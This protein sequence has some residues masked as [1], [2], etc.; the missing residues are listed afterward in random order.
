MHQFLNWCRRGYII[1]CKFY[2]PV[3]QQYSLDQKNWLAFTP[4]LDW[5]LTPNLT[6]IKVPAGAPK[7][8][9]GNKVVGILNNPEK[10]RYR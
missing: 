8:S 10:R 2:A 7:N 5:Y 6:G 3:N 9:P 4:R 1:P